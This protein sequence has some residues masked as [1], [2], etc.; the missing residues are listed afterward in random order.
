M[1]ITKNIIID[2]DSFCLIMHE[3]RNRP[4]VRIQERI[5]ITAIIIYRDTVFVVD[6]RLIFRIKNKY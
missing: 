1:L 2:F 3:K 4:K 5:A 6:V